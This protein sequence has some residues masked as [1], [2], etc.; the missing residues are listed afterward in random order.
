MTCESTAT[1]FGDGLDSDGLQVRVFKGDDDPKEHYIGRGVIVDLTTGAENAQSTIERIDSCLVNSGSLQIKWAGCSRQA[2]GDDGA[3]RGHHH[4]SKTM[5]IVIAV[6]V[7]AA[8]AGVIGTFLWIR[9]SGQHSGSF[10]ND[11]ENGGDHGQANFTPLN[12]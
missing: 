10:G 3:K 12:E 5:G 4:L 7:F 11:V 9:K 6:A 8:V 1:V 2:P